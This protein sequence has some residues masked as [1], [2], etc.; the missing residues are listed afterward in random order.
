LPDLKDSEKESP[1]FAML[2][3]QT[4]MRSPS[5]GWFM[6]WLGIIVAVILIYLGVT[7]A[8]DRKE[9]DRY[10]KRRGS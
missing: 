5:A 6:T 9:E 3:L 1:V 7:A 2:M 4:Q 10:K 8:A